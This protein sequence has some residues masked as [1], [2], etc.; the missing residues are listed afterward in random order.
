MS[1]DPSITIAQAWGDDRARLLAAKGELETLK[2]ALDLEVDL[3]LDSDAKITA[4][5]LVSDF[6]MRID[7]IDRAVARLDELLA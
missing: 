1:I 4:R 7:Q 5:Q 6:P 2:A 3:Y